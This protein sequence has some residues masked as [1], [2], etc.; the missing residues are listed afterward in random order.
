MSGSLKGTAA[1]AFSLIK[2]PIGFAHPHVV[3]FFRLFRSYSHTQ[4]YQHHIGFIDGEW[5][6]TDGGL[7][8]FRDVGCKLQAAVR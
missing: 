5:S 2:R 3:I 4:A 1:C 6:N 7:N 8:P